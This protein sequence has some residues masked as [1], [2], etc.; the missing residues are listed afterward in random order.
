MPATTRSITSR[1]R[2]VKPATRMAAAWRHDERS[3]E[4]A[5][6]CSARLMQASS[7]LG[8]SRLLDKIH[9]PGP[10]RL[11]RHGDVSLA[12]NDDGWQ[13]LA[14]RRKLGEKLESVHAGH[15]DIGEEAALLAGSKGV[16]EG[17]GACIS[18]DRVAG[19]RQQDLHGLACTAIVI[20]HV[21]RRGRGGVCHLWRVTRQPLPWAP[22]AVRPSSCRTSCNSSSAFCGFFRLT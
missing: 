17:R 5:A 14:R 4:L 9:R 6:C 1:S 8:I 18:L 13:S 11:D 3:A 22:S 12:S 2:L 21:D 7:A 16:E 15:A 20:D 10:H 19:L